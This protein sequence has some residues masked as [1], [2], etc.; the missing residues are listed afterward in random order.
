MKT[1]GYEAYYQGIYGGLSFEVHALN[2]TMDMTVGTEGISLK[3]IRNPVDGSSTFS[4]ACMFC[5][6]ALNDLYEYL[7]DGEE[8]KEEFRKFLD[9]FQ[10]KRDIT[11]QN[12][13]MIKNI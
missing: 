1:T 3:W 13:D 9:D 6:S 5:I 8:E 11:I 7:K 12:L 2:S 4:L 10:R